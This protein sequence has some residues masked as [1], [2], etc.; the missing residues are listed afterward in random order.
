[1]GADALFIPFRVRFLVRNLLMLL[2]CMY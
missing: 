1:V 2:D